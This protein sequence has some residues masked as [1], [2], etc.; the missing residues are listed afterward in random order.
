[1]Y[2]ITCLHNQRIDLYTLSSSKSKKFLKKLIKKI[3]LGFQVGM[4]GKWR[5]RN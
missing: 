5:L 1:M 3:G 4:H 2:L